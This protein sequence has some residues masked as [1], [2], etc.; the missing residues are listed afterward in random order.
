M[1]PALIALVLVLYFVDPFIGDWDGMDY[2][3]LALNGQPS[4]MALGRSLFIFANH[5]LFLVARAL[6]NVAP[7]NAYLI[8]KYAVVA[9]APVAVIACWVLTRDISGSLYTATIAALLIAFSPVFVLY[10]GQVMTDVPSVL[11]LATALIIHMRGVQQKRFWLVLLGAGLLGLGVNLRETMAFYAPWLV[12]APFVFGWKF[13]RREVLYVAA[14]CALFVLLGFGWFAYWFITDPIYRMGWYGWRESMREESARHPVVLANLRPYFLYYLISAPL[15]FLTVLF[16]PVLEWRKH[17]LSPMLLLWLVAFFANALLFFN[18][19]TT[20]NWRYFLTGLPG[21]VPLGACWLLIVARKRMRT[22]HRAFVACTTVI[23][24]FA[25]I[26]LISVRPVSSEFVQRRAMSKQYRDRLERV[27][28]DA[29]IM[30]GAQTVAVNY[31]ASIGS[32]RWTTIG[33]GGG[34]PGD[35]LVSVIQNHL[36][37]GRRV[38]LDADSR[39][40]VPCGWQRDEIP[41][42]VALEKH[43]SFRHVNDTIY[44]L[45]WL[46]DPA[47]RDN[48]NLSRLLPENRPEDMKKCPVGRD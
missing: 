29:V 11:L 9:Q 16:A 39:W 47:A 43:F 31:W 44:E 15:V 7:E 41:G 33:T 28:P 14:S 46:G 36:D 38:F 30:S 18:Y 45:S 35:R 17:R 48:P 21:L 32:G 8:F 25:T 24:L 23:V 12:L 3:V 1:P 10:G 42:I 19:S 22:E 40:W 37:Q 13:G 20:V 4:S 34:W 2:T 27:P 5:F 26:F 6:F